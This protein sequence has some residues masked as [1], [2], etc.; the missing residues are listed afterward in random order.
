MK[1]VAH[2]SVRSQ[3]AI[4]AALIERFCFNHQIFSDA[5]SAFITHQWD[6]ATVVDIPAW[7]KAGAELKVNGRGDPLPGILI[8][9]LGSERAFGL[10]RICECVAEIALSQLYGAYRPAESLRFLNLAAEEAGICLVGF[11]AAGI[12]QQHE[13]NLNGWG[14]P[15]SKEELCRWQTVARNICQSRNDKKAE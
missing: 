13:P 11:E 15:I 9:E 7:D 6:L 3:Q 14:S 12:F 5:V 10:A 2:F 8:E 1:S 4:G